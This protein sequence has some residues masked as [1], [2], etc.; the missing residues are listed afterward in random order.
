MSE[1]LASPTLTGAFIVMG[2]T[3]IIM[4]A[5]P[6]VP[7]QVIIW[8]TALIFGLLAGWD[9]LGWGT[10]ILLSVLMIIAG[11]MDEVGRWLGAKS[12]GA[13]WSAIVIGLI[14]GFI[15]MLIFELPGAIIGALSGIAWYE[16]RK[17]KDWKRSFKAAT[18]YVVGLL[19][20]FVVR[21]GIAVIMVIIFSI[22]VL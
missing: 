7:G 2:V 10:F 15:G 13:S 12:G 20:S 8:L 9:K 5:V 21:F 6:I 18:G 19:A 17:D 3:L 14:T 11:L 4:L 1:I 22:R 16:Y